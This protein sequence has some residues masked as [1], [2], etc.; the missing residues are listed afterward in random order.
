[1]VAETGTTEVLSRDDRSRR[2]EVVVVVVNCRLGTHGLMARPAVCSF[3]CGL[4]CA[5]RYAMLPATLSHAFSR[6][7]F[8]SFFFSGPSRTSHH[9]KRK[10]SDQPAFP[11][12]MFVLLT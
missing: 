10:D 5:S 8:F 3:C 6:F 7:L 1:M 2:W 4:P 12:L 11:D 9:R